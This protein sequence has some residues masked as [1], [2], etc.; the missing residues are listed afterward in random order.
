MEREKALV[1][2]SFIIGLGVFLPKFASIITLPIVTGCLTKY[3]YGTYDLILILISLV[4]PIATLQ[5]ASAAFRFL[6]ES[7]NDQEKCSKYITNILIF[8][9]L[10]SIIPMVVIF[11]VVNSYELFTRIIIC[12]YFLF[13][14]LLT[15]FQQINRGLG[16]NKLY[17]SST[18]LNAFLN[19]LM[20]VVL[21]RIFKMGLLGVVGA[22]VVAN[23]TT[24][25]FLIFGCHIGKYINPK[26]FNKEIIIELVSFSWPM[27]PNNLSSWV[28]TLS[29]RLLLS[30][31]MGVEV[32]AVYA[33]AKKIPNLLT[34]VQSTFSMAWQE[35]ASIS[36][37]DSDI[38]V[39]YASMFDS[40]INITIGACAVLLGMSPI[41]FKLLIKGD[42]QE[43]YSQ[44]PILFLGMTFV[45]LASYQAGIYIA[46]KKTR[47][48][49][50]TTVIAACI[51]TII[52]LIA[53]PLIGMYAASIST[54]V[55]YVFLFVYRM[56]DLKRFH[57]IKYNY[58]KIIGLLLG[59]TLMCAV[60]ALNI[61][62]LNYVLLIIGFVLAIYLNRKLLSQ[63]FKRISLI[64]RNTD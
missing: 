64:S 1:K 29:D 52:D 7:R 37:N 38:D 15:T 58:K 59:L 12:L 53:I 18:I 8:T 27:I 51:N 61:N 43:A 54:L 44:I 55:S 10:M 22:L 48:I 16:K 21:I 11:F 40:V 28:M 17:S 20:V 6:I 33:V 46:D 9:V 24:C 34:S 42:Y 49:G 2:N 50:L 31:F 26:Y 39:Y 41:L 25:F 5:I 62:S 63:I 14:I 35:N 23:A 36:S 45:T 4:L 30:L 3:E 32:N 57:N 56:I 19:M 13:D 47:E 60:S